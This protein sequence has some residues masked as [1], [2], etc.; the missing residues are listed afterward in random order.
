MKRVLIV[1]M[2]VLVAKRLI[3]LF[4]RVR[5]HRSVEREK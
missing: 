2:C 5:R 4:L 1:L 3:R